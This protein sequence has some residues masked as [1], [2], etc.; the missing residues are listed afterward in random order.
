MSLVPG[1]AIANLY[2]VGP[3]KNVYTKASFSLGGQIN[4]AYSATYNGGVVNQ[5]AQGQESGLAGALITA[6]TIPTPTEDGFGRSNTLVIVLLAPGITSNA[7]GA[8]AYSAWSNNNYGVAVVLDQNNEATSCSTYLSPI[9]NQISGTVASDSFILGIVAETVHNIGAHS[10]TYSSESV[11]ELCLS[12][13]GTIY[14]TGTAQYTVA[15]A[16]AGGARYYFLPQ[17]YVNMPPGGSGVGAA[18][19]S[20]YSQPQNVINSIARMWQ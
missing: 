1:V 2:P 3:N 13:T 10:W 5:F 8:C 6:T 14:G 7:A 11:S 9:N 16:T 20:G 12:N 19:S 18:C 4:Q 15:L 17:N